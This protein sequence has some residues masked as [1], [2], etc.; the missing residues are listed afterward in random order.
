[1]SGSKIDQAI[2]NELDQQISAAQYA[3]QEQLANTDSILNGIEPETNT[4]ST[5]TYSE[6]T[7]NTDV[8]DTNLLYTTFLVMAPDTICEPPLDIID[9]VFSSSD[10]SV[11][12]V[13]SSGLV[14]RGQAEAGSWVVINFDGFVIDPVYGKLPVHGDIAL[15]LAPIDPLPVFL[16]GFT[17]AM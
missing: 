17:V 3:T 13:D 15:T 6:D 16:T 8:V 4:D 11:A 5:P 14:T 9:W 12:T 1:M 10:E 2:L 7:D